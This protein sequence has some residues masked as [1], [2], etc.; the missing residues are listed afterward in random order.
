MQ[1]NLGPEGIA[2]YAAAMANEIP[3]GV[4]AFAGLILRIVSQ[5]R[6]S[7][8]EVSTGVIIAG[9]LAVAAGT[10][11]AFQAHRAGRVFRG[12]RPPAPYR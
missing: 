5:G 2:L 4:T 12:G 1:Q 8:V 11:R 9:C 7:L 10:F 6:G 3:G